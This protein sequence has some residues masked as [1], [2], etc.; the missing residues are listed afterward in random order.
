MDL[1]SLVLTVCLVASP[2]KCRDENLLFE[3]R[4]ELTLCM[5]LAQ[6]EIAKW[7]AQHPALKVK[8]WKCAFPDKSRSL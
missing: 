8:R 2:D 5:L 6:S 7:S 3:R 4:G 1:V